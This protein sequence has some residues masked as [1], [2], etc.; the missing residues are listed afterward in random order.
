MLI[1]NNGPKESEIWSFKMANGDEVIATV[2]KIENKLGSNTYWLKKPAILARTNQGMV[3]MPWLLTAELETE[4]APIDD[5]TILT[6]VKTV[7]ELATQYSS[8]TSGI[9]PPPIPDAG[10]KLNK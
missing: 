2:A 6:K 10:F 3:M 1:A 9:L 5:R 4:L 7:K 8:Q